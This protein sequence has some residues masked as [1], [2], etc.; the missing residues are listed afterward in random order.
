MGLGFEWPQSKHSKAT[1]RQSS[2]N[3]IDTLVGILFCNCNIAR[4]LN[5]V[6]IELTNLLTF[7]TVTVTIDLA[8][9]ANKIM[10]LRE[11]LHLL[12]L[13]IV[14]IVSNL[15]NAFHIDLFCLFVV[16]PIFCSQ[17][18]SNIQISNKHICVGLIVSSVSGG[19]LRCSFERPP[20]F[21]FF[22]GGGAP[23]K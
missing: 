19:R 23:D 22:A 5:Y 18:K 9:I 11:H 8:N 16:V 12:L 17:F 2:S 7:I 6:P 10:A 15:A 3:L 13:D 14:A 1:S 4:S 20:L 21:L